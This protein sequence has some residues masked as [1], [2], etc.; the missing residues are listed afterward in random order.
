M[1]KLNYTIIEI[2]QREWTLTLP[3]R[4]M[5]VVVNEFSNQ[6]NWYLQQTL[7]QAWTIEAN[8][9]NFFSWT[10]VAMFLWC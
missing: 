1:N 7:C 5:F 10:E 8:E 4:M 3:E 2:E 9:M 6:Q